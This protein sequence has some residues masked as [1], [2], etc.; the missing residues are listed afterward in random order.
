MRAAAKIFEIVTKTMQQQQKCNQRYNK[1]KWNLKELRENQLSNYGCLDDKP[2][3][4][5]KGILR[6]KSEINIKTQ[7]SEKYQI[8]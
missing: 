5:Q 8:T 1:N 7:R 4:I 6:N 3:Y 2:K